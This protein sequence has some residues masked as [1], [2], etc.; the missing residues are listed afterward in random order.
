MASHPVT[1]VQFLH[2]QMAAAMAGQ[3]DAYYELG[4]AYAVGSSGVD[5]DL[6][7]AHKWFNLAAMS[8]DERAQLDRSEVAASMTPAEVA[9][10]Q[11]EAR[12]F[13]MQTRH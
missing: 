1:E 10:A 9:A 8:G 7:E 6:V 4:V 3:P 12:A 2:A 13:L 5:I 11:R